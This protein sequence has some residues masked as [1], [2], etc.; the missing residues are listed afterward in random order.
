MVVLKFYRE[1]R[2]VPF[3]EN[4]ARWDNGTE[5][6]CDMTTTLNSAL[7]DPTFLLDPCGGNSVPDDINCHGIDLM[8]CNKS[9]TLFYSWRTFWDCL[10]V[11]GAAWKRRVEDR[12]PTMSRR[13]ELSYTPEVLDVNDRFLEEFDDVGVLNLTLECAQASCEEW[14]MDGKCSVK[15]PN[16]PFRYEHQG[17]SFDFSETVSLLGRVCDDL[18]TLNLDIAGPGV[19]SA[20]EH[21]SVE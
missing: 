12:S 20:R 21:R 16:V 3:Q 2:D 8:K 11:T 14:A 18:P 17:P 9:S 6:P 1:L 5:P 4:P 15:A 13:A 10:T 7:S 19:S